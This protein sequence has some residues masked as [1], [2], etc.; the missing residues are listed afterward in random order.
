MENCNTTFLH[1]HIIIQLNTKIRV[2]L[3]AEM[4]SPYIC[5]GR[6]YYKESIA[7]RGDIVRIGVW[8]LLTYTYSRKKA[9]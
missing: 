1:A 2:K 7:L 4:R 9:P 8:P 5:K 6:A 3:E